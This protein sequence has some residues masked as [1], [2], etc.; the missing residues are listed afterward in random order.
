MH[1][2]ETQSNFTAEAN[3]EKAKKETSD[4]RIA[5]AGPEREK[6]HRRPSS[7]RV[8]F[9]ERQPLKVH[10]KPCTVPFWESGR[11][12]GPGLLC[13]RV[14]GWKG[15]LLICYMLYVLVDTPAKFV[16]KITVKLPRYAL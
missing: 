2:A 12:R 14:T 5:N 1:R 10:E 15:R 9:G 3:H 4:T 6:N 8:H 16:R 7:S 13:A 11:S